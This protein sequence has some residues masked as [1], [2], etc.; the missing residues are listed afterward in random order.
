MSPEQQEIEN[1]CIA[2]LQEKDAVKLTKLVEHLNEM[3]ELRDRE[4][5]EFLPLSHIGQKPKAS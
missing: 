4:R 2:I 5:A 3:L 1:V